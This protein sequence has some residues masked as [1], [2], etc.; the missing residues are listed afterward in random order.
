MNR[1][2]YLASVGTVASVGLAG[3]SSV[4]GVFEDDPCGGDGCDIGMTRNEFVPEEY[5]VRVGETVVWKNTSGAD[6]TVTALENTL[7][8]GAAYFA[9]GDYE[10]ERTARDAWHEYRGGRLGTRETYEHT[11][12]VPG[13]YDY[14]CEPHIRGGMVGTIIVTE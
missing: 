13:T 12:E 2:A 11:F 14:I 9:T 7:P 5:E 6:H 1:R 10:D 3:C 8:E 4:L